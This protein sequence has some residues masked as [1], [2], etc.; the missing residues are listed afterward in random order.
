[1]GKH[2]VPGV[3]GV[4]AGLGVLGFAGNLDGAKPLIDD[5]IH[6]G[7]K[8]TKI[9][10]GAPDTR[11]DHI[12][13]F[14][15]GMISGE[16][17]VKGHRNIVRA[18]PIPNC[19]IDLDLTIPFIAEPIIELKDVEVTTGTPDTAGKYDLVADVTGDVK[20]LNPRSILNNPQVDFDE[21][22]FNHCSDGSYSGLI[23][24]I[25]KIGGL[26]TD[27]TAQ[28]MVDTVNTQ[29]ILDTNGNPIETDASQAIHQIYEDDLRTDLQALYP[30]AKKIDINWPAP[31]P[32]YDVTQTPSYK[33]LSEAISDLEDE[34]YK[35]NADPVKSCTFES[36][37]L[38]VSPTKGT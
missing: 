23:N 33:A 14:A 28:C 21:G 17:T 16:V 15:V 18:G 34:D 12:A 36:L 2:F 9:E 6:F 20:I 4:A 11:V 10:V 32:N 1:M 13:A 38:D 19:K 30:N 5:G 31:D 27:T 29:T 24:N 3:M 37:T 8:K 7:D 25:L 35:I 22:G 26:A